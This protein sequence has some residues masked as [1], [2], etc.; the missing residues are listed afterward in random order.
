MTSDAIRLCRA[1][2]ATHSKSFALAS[3][4]LPSGARDETAAVYAYCRRADDLIDIASDR[5]P[6]EIVAALRAELFTLYEG[7]EEFEPELDLFQS[8]VR[9]HGIPRHYPEELLAGMAMDATDTVYDELEQLL[10]YCFRVAGTVGLMMRT[11]PPAASG[12]SP[13]RMPV[14]PGRTIPI[15]PRIS[16]TPMKRMKATGT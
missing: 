14:R 2:I 6:T 13:G 7:E 4:L 16:Q 11:R 3:R 9:C 1:S 5:R 10:L 15:A 12:V 8:V